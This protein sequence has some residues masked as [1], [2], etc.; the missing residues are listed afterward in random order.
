[1]VFVFL[2]VLSLVY[3]FDNPYENF[4]ATEVLTVDCK[5]TCVC[6]V[7]IFLGVVK[8]GC[9]GEM[10]CCVVV[11]VWTISS[12]MK[13][14]GVWI[15]CCVRFLV[16]LRFSLCMTVEFKLFFRVSGKNVL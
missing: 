9:I 15:S 7:F 13:F 2:T 11:V 10:L 16:P 1:M 4:G 3:T 12:F 5:F 8:L 6:S 14:D